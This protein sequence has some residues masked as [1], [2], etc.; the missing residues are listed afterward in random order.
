VDAAYQ[1]VVR[2][3]SKDV[4][5][6]G[7]SFKAGTD[8]LRESPLVE[9]IERLIGKGYRVRVF[10]RN[11]SLASLHGANRAYIEQEIPHIAS[12]LASDLQDVLDH[13]DTIVIGNGDA[14]FK[15]LAARM[16]PDH[17]VI[18]LIRVGLDEAV[19]GDRYEGI[20]W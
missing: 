10:D 2:G 12:I 15:T 17:R 13:A 1:L 6:L 16:R 20:S 14:E 7:M 4:G 5:V 3:G 18:D 9:L 19:V 11:V 8:D